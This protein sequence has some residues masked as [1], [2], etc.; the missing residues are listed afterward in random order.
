ML[1]LLDDLPS[2]TSQDE[3]VSQFQ[4]ENEMGG[5]KVNSGRPWLVF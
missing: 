3:Y 1:L 5:W 4:L 2:A